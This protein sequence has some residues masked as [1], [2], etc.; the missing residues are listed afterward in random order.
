MISI[1]TWTL[2]VRVPFESMCCVEGVKL[3]CLLA[4]KSSDSNLGPCPVYVC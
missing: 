2:R 4:L 1:G 3:A